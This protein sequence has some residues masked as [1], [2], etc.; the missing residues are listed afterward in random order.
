M[1]HICWTENI[2]KFL[3]NY[4]CRDCDKFWSQSFNFQRHFRICS[5]S[6]TDRYPTGP[7]QLNETVFEKMRNLDIEVKTTDSKT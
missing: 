4:R 1:T 5:K 6:I 3:K 2:D 7:N